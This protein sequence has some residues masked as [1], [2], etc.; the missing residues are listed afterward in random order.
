MPRIFFSG[1]SDIYFFPCRNSFFLEHFFSLLQEKKT[2]LAAHWIVTED[3]RLLE[4]LEHGKEVFNNTLEPKARFLIKISVERHSWKAWKTEQSVPSPWNFNI[5]TAGKTI[6]F[7]KARQLTLFA[8]SRPISVIF[9]QVKNINSFKKNIKNLVCSWCPTTNK[10]CYAFGGR[11]E[12]LLPNLAVL[13]N[14]T[15]V[16]L[17]CEDTNIISWI[18]LELSNWKLGLIF[19]L[20]SLVKKL[21]AFKVDGV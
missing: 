3:F 16:N 18:P 15:T 12:T 2:T 20:S 1:Y 5:A 17:T 9:G 4:L 19:K 13:S 21:S 11:L 14:L 7:E 8:K 6:H 10:D